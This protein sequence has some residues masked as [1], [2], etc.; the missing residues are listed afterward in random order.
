M[1]DNVTLPGTGKVVAAED[2]GSV[3]YQ[4]MKVVDGTVA[5][6]TPMIVTAS[7]AAKV[8]GSAVN[9]PVTIATIPLATNA[10]TESGHLATIDTSTARIPAQGQALAAA[11]LP[12]VMTAA[13]ITTLTPLS[14]ATAKGTQGANGLAVQDLKDSGRAAVLITLDAFSVATTAETL[15]TL[16]WSLDGAAMATGTSYN[17][18]AG[19]R[20]RIQSITFTVSTVGG[21]TTAAT[22]TARFRVNA[23]GAAVLASPLQMLILT[24]GTGS[25]NSV[26]NSFVQP[27]IPD[28]WELPGSA[29]LGVTIT[30]PGYVV[31]TAAP[32]VNMTIVAYEY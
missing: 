28:G 9:Q 18:T 4:R 3:D 29:G 27:V 32:R 16:T 1:A 12:V 6:T 5:G 20:L 14:T 8:D 22:V 24:A 26:A 15:V 30:I 21:N 19:K 10:A 25:A 17:V 2:I 13:Q 23:G 31:T 7:G 11:S